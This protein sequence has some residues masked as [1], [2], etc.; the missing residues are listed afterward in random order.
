MLFNSS[1]FTH[2]VPECVI[3][4]LQKL[5]S[6]CILFR[7]PVFWPWSACDWILLNPLP[8]LQ[9]TCLFL[10]LWVFYSGFDFG[11]AQLL[12]RHLRQLPRN[13]WSL[14]IRITVISVYFPSPLFSCTLTCLCLCKLCLII[15]HIRRHIPLPT[16][17]M[18]S[19]IIKTG[20]FY[21]SACS[22]GLGK[23]WFYVLHKIQ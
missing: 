1:C 9:V 16:M 11:L 12:H 7:L 17:A 4:S 6:V 15:Q 19:L 20:I 14:A 23:K 18:I 2:P 3:P 21:L 5:S 13:V 22:F 8:S 10:F